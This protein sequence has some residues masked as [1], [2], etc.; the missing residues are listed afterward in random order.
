MFAD[1]TTTATPDSV[2]T[3]TFDIL[4][5]TSMTTTAKRTIVTSTDLMSTANPGMRV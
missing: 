2:T 4:P 5:V 3:R 1:A